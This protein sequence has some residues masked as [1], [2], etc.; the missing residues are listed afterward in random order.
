MAEYVHPEREA[1]DILAQSEFAS[2]QMGEW[3]WAYG[4]ILLG[5]E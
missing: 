1:P 4:H 5:D 3:I 2:M